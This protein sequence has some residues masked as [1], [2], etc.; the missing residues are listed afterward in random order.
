MKRRHYRGWVSKPNLAGCCRSNGT[1]V[2]IQKTW[3]E[4]N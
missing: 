1:D 2:G 4:H 3:Y